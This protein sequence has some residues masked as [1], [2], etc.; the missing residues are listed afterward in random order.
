MHD[1]R[2]VGRVDQRV[3]AEKIGDV[4]NR[5]VLTRGNEKE[6]RVDLVDTN[7]LYLA[8]CLGTRSNKIRCTRMQRCC[9]CRSKREDTDY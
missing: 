4:R 1:L 3:Y 8:M 9:W 6:L 2:I 5:E 7:Q